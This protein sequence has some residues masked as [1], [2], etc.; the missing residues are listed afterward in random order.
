MN[1]ALMMG[2]ATPVLNII[3]TLN[4]HCP[5]TEMYILIIGLAPNHGGVP[6]ANC[7]LTLYSFLLGFI[8]FTY[9]LVC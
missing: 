9:F 6:W 4:V 5:G 1:I 8:F 3:Q 2:I 7:I